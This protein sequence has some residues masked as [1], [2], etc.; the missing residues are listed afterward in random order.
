MTYLQ[1]YLPWLAVMV[2]GL[3]A[4]STSRRV[5]LLKAK[6]SL[7]TSAVLQLIFVLFLVILF[8]SA[9]LL[10]RATLHSSQHLQR[11]WFVHSFSLCFRLH[12]N[13]RRRRC[14]NSCSAWTCVRQAGRFTRSVGGRPSSVADQRARR[15]IYRAASPAG[16]SRTRSTWPARRA[17]TTRMARGSMGCTL[18]RT[19]NTR[20]SDRARQDQSES[21]L[22]PPA[23]RHHGV[24]QHTHERSRSNRGRFEIGPRR[25]AIAPGTRARPRL[26]RRTGQAAPRGRKSLRKTS[27]VSAT[28]QELPTGGHAGSQL[29][30]SAGFGGHLADCEE[31]VGA[32]AFGTSRRPPFPPTCARTNEAPALA[33]AS[34]PI[35]RLKPDAAYIWSPQFGGYGRHDGSA[36]SGGMLRLP[37]EFEQR[38]RTLARGIAS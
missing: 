13:Y 7:A 4:D 32:H 36:V 1:I 26:P 18:A 33:G 22:V 16:N 19:C 8:L 2:A 14:R 27:D 6:A 9:I 5:A 21:H 23:L 34:R 15:L 35:V 25:P 30:Q 37:A 11:P 20:P 28:S 29:R 38:A 12:Q 3:L 10:A 17:R 31:H 24:Q